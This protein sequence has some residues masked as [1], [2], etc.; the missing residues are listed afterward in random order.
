MNGNSGGVELILRSNGTF[1]LR[2]Y[3]V[4]HID[5]IIYTVYSRYGVD[6]VQT[7]LNATV[8]MVWPGLG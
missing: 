8:G 7:H 2:F 6:H 1:K 3:G 5:F 4:F